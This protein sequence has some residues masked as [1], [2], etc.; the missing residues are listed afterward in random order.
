[1]TTIVLMNLES[2]RPVLCNV[3]QVLP[4]D[5]CKC[6][7]WVS[8]FK[9]AKFFYTILLRCLDNGH[10]MVDKTVLFEEKPFILLPRAL[11]FIHRGL[12]HEYVK[13]VFWRRTK[14]NRHCI[15]WAVLTHILWHL[16]LISLA[17]TRIL[18]RLA[19][20]WALV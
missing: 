6:S 10:A 1:M 11:H 7:C 20:F 2:T 15:P 19:Y 17:R 16:L 5:S 8:N 3:T 9:M 13:K 14:E 12:V 4:T 18:K